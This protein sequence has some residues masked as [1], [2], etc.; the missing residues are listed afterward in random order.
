[1]SEW[2]SM[3]TAPKDGTQILGALIVRGYGEQWWERHVIA[4]ND[5]KGGID[6]NSDYYHGWSWDDYTHWHELPP[7]PAN[8]T[9]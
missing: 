3:E 8:P 4:Y 7:S 9:P 1:M 2:R 6:E 5:D